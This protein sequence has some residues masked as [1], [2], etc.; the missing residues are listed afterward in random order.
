MLKVLWVSNGSISR[1]NIVTHRALNIFLLI[2]FYEARQGPTK[3]GIVLQR[4][5]HGFL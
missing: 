1:V 2:F 5:K 4:P 3:L